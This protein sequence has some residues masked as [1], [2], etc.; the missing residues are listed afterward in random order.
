MELRKSVLTA[1]LAGIVMFGMHSVQP[2]VQAAP[3][4]VFQT[5]FDCPEW[6][7]GNGDPCSPNDGID[8]YGGWTTSAGGRDQITSAAN[9]PMGGGRG[10][11]HQRGPGT[12]NNGGSILINIPHSPQVWLR[13]YMRFSAGFQ[14]VGGAPHYTKDIYWNV[15]EPGWVF[16]GFLDSMLTTH[17]SGMGMN[18]PNQYS[19]DSWSAINSGSVGDGQWHAYEQYLNTNTGQVRMWRDGK[20]VLER[21]G[22]N[23]GMTNFK[24]FALGENQNEVLGFHYTDYDDIAVSTTGYIGPLGS[25]APTPPLPPRNLRIVS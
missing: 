1:A 23:F 22:L 9:N 19:S 6:A 13:F 11:R 24:W 14:F 12:N 4:L 7:Q 3:E 17:L 25:T 18:S 20:L 15:H 10:F 2:P 8:A 5:S 16:F 21:S